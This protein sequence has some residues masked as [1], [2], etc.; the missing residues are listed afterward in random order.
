MRQISE[1]FWEQNIDVYHLFIDFY[2]A[3]DTVCGKKIWS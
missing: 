1:E 2:A 3:Y